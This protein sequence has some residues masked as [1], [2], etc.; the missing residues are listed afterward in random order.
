MRQWVRNVQVLRPWKSGHAKLLLGQSVDI[1]ANARAA[2]SDEQHLMAAAKW[3][4]AAQ[5]A[6]KDGGIAGRYKLAVGWTSSYPETTGYIVPTLL[7]LADHLNDDAYRERARRAVG[8]LL[9]IQLDSGAFPGLEIAENRT[10]ASAF[11]SAQILHGLTAWHRATGDEQ[12]LKAAR[13]AADW[14]ISIQ[15]P[16]GSWTRH[17]YA[18]VANDYSAHL[19]CW[20]AEFGQHTG[21]QRYLDAASRHVDW[22]LSHIDTETGWFPLAGFSTAQHNAGEAFTHTIAYTIWG[23][24]YSS[25]IL[26]REDGI[27]AAARA[28][29]AVARRLELQKSLPGILNREWRAAH[30][31]VCL[32]GNCQMALIWF[33]LYGINGDETLLNAAL[34]AIDEVKRAQ[35]LG[36]RN[37]GINGGIPGSFPIWGQ[38]ITNA[39]P[40]WAAKYFIDAL[41]EKKRTL[42]TLSNRPK[43]KQRVAPDVPRSLPAAV[44]G[45]ASAQTVVLLTSS[46]SRKVPQFLEAWKHLAFKPA[47]VVVE[48]AAPVPAKQR[49][50]EILR[51]EGFKGV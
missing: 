40:N 10:E 21:E 7:A 13:R 6:S 18:G 14:L 9:S 47:A 26:K 15:D 25:Q 33:R 8:F 50:K 27:K 49:V 42:E 41:L 36:N 35:P 39:I 17:C 12:T 3:L 44:T 38:Y 23:V 28:A 16:N 31:P 37:P 29:G 48:E 34:K 46:G 5:D 45:G 1:N 4:A 2:V 30:M 11:N 32:T 19:S 51:Q 24:L 43:G 22:V 20:L